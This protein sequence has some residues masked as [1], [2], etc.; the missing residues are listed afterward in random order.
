MD[1][2]RIS[3]KKPVY[4]S[5]D[6]PVYCFYEAN[7]QLYIV[8]GDD[9]YASLSVGQIVSLM[10]RA[11]RGGYTHLISEDFEIKEFS[12][13]TIVIDKPTTN[14]L[15]LDTYVDYINTD[16]EPAG[17]ILTFKEPHNVFLQDIVAKKPEICLEAYDV[18]G[19]ILWRK[20]NIDITISPY[21]VAQTSDLYR[22]DEGEGCAAGTI[23]ATYTY[24]PQFFYL[25]SVTL[26]DETETSLQCDKIDYLKFTCDNKGRIS[27]YNPYYFSASAYTTPN[28]DI[29]EERLECMFWTDRLHGD[30]QVAS[31][32]KKASYWNVP[33][34]LEADVDWRIMDKDDSALLSL[35]DRIIDS[36][37]PDTINMER[38][39]CVPVTDLDGSPATAIT[40]N[41]H[42]RQRVEK[43][44]LDSGD[45]VYDEGWHVNEDGYWNGMEDDDVGA[46]LTASGSVSDMLGYLDFSDND[47]FYRK[48]ALSKSFA[49]LSFY[50]SNEVMS[51]SLMTYNTVFMPSGDLYG[52]LL[53]QKSERYEGSISATT[54]AVFTDV[55]SVSGR[56]DTQLRITSE[57]DATQSAEGFNVYLFDSDIP[58]NSTRTIYMKVEFNHAKYGK[59]IPLVMMGMNDKI[60]VK[61]Y[62]SSL[63]IPVIIQYINNRYTYY[64]P[65]AIN[66]KATRQI[67]I[68][69]YEPKLSD[70]N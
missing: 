56:L 59:T 9:S 32:T 57:V 12:N 67:I 6:L 26:M 62:L 22:Y 35:A 48:S 64:F 60:T 69:L 63:Y 11:D 33:V 68:N 61:N 18:D 37:I 29:E 58:Q 8:I 28:M 15:H 3:L 41:F 53:K 65:T 44:R 52:A 25:N 2:L 39:K 17:M 55:P 13:R 46:F 19:K 38:V 51:H 50:S 31:L 16:D 7:D 42:F 36:S 47:V 4:G 43:E 66:S 49:R 23:D 10:R 20:R 5:I 70:D 40:I 1:T 24:L 34:G 21:G 30:T 14:I 45:I 54:S 27:N